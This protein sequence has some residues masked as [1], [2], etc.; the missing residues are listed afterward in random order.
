MMQTVSNINKSMIDEI[1]SEIQISD[2]KYEEAEQRY[3]AVGDWLNRKDSKVAEFN[4]KIYSQ[5]SFLL[6]TATKPVTK[7]DE[8]DVDIVSE[9]NLS[10]KTISQSALKKMIGEEIKAYAEAR[11]MENEPSESKR[12]WTLIYANGTRFHIDVLPA[13]P[14]NRLFL[15]FRNDARLQSQWLETAIAITDR[16]HSE[17]DIITDDWLVSNPKGYFQWFKERMIVQ[18]EAR[19][20]VL[21]EAYRFEVEDLPFYKVRTPLQHVIQLLKYHRDVMFENDTDNK[22]ISII[23]TTLAA[24]AYNNERNLIDAL[25]NVSANMRSFIT[26]GYDGCWQIVNP[27]NP[28]EN[29][30]D[31]WVKNSKLAENFFKWLKRIE[32][33]FSIENLTMGTQP[34]YESFQ[35]SLV[36]ALRQ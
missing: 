35:Q 18:Y 17:F 20:K 11:N 10:K 25:V 22:P 12:C 1:L 4:P 31:K 26:K 23:I 36:I 5:G 16:T 19:F 27:V 33:D 30:A 32:K 3:N 14:D 24:H 7:K 21:K 15:E 9:L 13:I 28:N 2:S 6:G 34:L 8:H 29:F